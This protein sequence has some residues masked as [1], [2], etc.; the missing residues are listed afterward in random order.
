MSGDRTIEGNITSTWLESFM[1][2]FVERHLGW[3]WNMSKYP[4]VSEGSNVFQKKGTCRF[5][6][7]A[8]AR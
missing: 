2:G 7:M 3:M 4:T 5:K 6:D 8:Q 1:D